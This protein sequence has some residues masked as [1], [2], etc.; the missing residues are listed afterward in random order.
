MMEDLISGILVVHR[1]V[2][3]IVIEFS[4]SV[5]DPNT[6]KFVTFHQR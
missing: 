2:F 3:Q 5:N 4:N 1:M 6:W